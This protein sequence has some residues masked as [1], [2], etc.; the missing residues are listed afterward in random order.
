METLSEYRHIIDKKTKEI[1]LKS[2]KSAVNKIDKNK[3]SFVGIVGSIEKE[4]S[5]DI[6]ILI[7]PG[8]KTKIGESIIELAK[9]YE[10]A[11][12]E[13][14][15]HHKRYYIVACPKFAMQE[16]THH[17]AAIE[18]G[19][20][21][22]IPLHSMF[23]TSYKDFKK[24]SPKKW[25]KRIKEDIITIHG[26]FEE[27]KKI[28]ALS[29]NK[30][31]PYFFVLDFEMNSRIKNFP[32]HLIRASAESLFEYLEKKY[33]IKIKKEIPH[34]IKE[35]DKEFVRLMKLLDKKTYS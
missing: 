20:S 11:E 29:Q 7:F 31:E 12:K 33:D 26:D 14:K 23:F 6:D 34:N 28:P 13:L 17:I 22:M 9:L 35:L 4:T 21:G 32:R 19:A 10:V 8:L 5:H 25:V 3:F 1:F 16:I 30:L 24:F 27:T 18:E 15:K 2:F